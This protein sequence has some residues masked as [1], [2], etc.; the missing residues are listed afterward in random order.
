MRMS[1]VWVISRDPAGRAWIKLVRA[2]D[3]RDPYISNAGAMQVG[4]IAGDAE[5]WVV[6]AIVYESFLN[7]SDESYA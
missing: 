4:H 5:V 1:S 3:P 7:T 2:F 6:E